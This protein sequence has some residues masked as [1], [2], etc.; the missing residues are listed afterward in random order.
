MEY[1]S[2]YFAAMSDWGKYHFGEI[3]KTTVLY[4]E[5]PVRGEGIELFSYWPN[6]DIEDFSIQALAL[7]YFH[8][9]LYS[10]HLIVLFLIAAFL[11]IVILFRK[12]IF[13]FPT[14]LSYSSIF[15]LGFLLMMLNEYF[16]PAPRMNYNF[17]LWLFVF[18]ILVLQYREI[19]P[20]PMALL[21]FGVL[22]ILGFS[23]VTNNQIIGEALIWLG[24]FLHLYNRINKEVFFS[25]SSSVKRNLL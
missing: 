8:I 18:S 24:T 20:W 2:G 13:A 22:F 16:I 21:V 11:M 25:L 4:P 19:A 10:V 23:W 15:L 6:W 3:E 12:K 1:W 5:N 7:Q 14:T 9:K 17:V